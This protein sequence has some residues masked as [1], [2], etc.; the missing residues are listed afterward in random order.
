V[1][2][3]RMKRT[4]SH[5][6]SGPNR[7]VM[8]VREQRTDKEKAAAFWRHQLFFPVHKDNCEQIF[9]KTKAFLRFEVF[10]AVTMK[11]GVFWVV[12]PCGSCKNRRFGGTRRHL[13]QSDKN[14]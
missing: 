5:K 10:T 3:L 8:A 7:E 1:C 9:W 13:H 2:N 14:R 4:A 12:T 6:R 11:N